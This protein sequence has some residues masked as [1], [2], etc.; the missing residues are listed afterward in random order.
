MIFFCN[1]SYLHILFQTKYME[2]CNDPDFE[3]WLTVFW[4]RMVP[5]V[6]ITKDSSI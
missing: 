2:L 3:K 4:P 6:T 5:A 1:A